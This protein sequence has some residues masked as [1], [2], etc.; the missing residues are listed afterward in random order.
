M[1]QGEEFVG[2][3]G[4]GF[5][6]RGR[7]PGYGIYATTKRIIGVNV[8]KIGRPF[9]GGGMAGLVNGQL[10][11]KLSFD[12]SARVIQ[13]L[14]EKKEFE[15]AKDEISRIEIKGPGPI[16]QGHIIIFPRTGDEA[17]VGILHKVGFQRLRELMQVFYPEALILV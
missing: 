16:S 17:K 8:R 9:L 12:E 11:P 4:G 7:L 1:E 14:D 13:E 10:T 6:S 5:L 2:G 15:I 3:F